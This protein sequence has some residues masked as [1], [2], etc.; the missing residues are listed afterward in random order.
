M[1][2]SKPAVLIWKGVE[3]MAQTS[4]KLLK[5]LGLSTGQQTTPTRKKN[6]KKSKK[7]SKSSYRKPSGE[8]K[9]EWSP[10]V[11]KL[12]AIDLSRT[13]P[14]EVD[15]YRNLLKTI[16]G[17]VTRTRKKLGGN[18][19]Y[20]REA[21]DRELNEMYK[22]KKPS[23]AKLNASLVT[24]ELAKYQ[25][26]FA[27]KTSSAAG[28]TQEQIEQ[29]KRIFGVTENGEARRVLTFEE[30]KAFWSLY[31]SFYE[32]HPNAF[33]RFDSDRV[34]QVL[35]QYMLFDELSTDEIKNLDIV[36]LTKKVFNQLKRE[37]EFDYDLP[38][39]NRLNPNEAFLPK[40]VSSRSL[41]AYRKS[42]EARRKK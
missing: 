39:F 13:K 1:T 32:L 29:S 4:K 2:K 33:G 30:S 12:M 27:S 21:L 19:S 37:T 6:S 28:A 9:Q 42:L 23:T 36:D 18:F 34:Q 40:A 16:R 8:V 15:N 14:N 7:S 11:K 3:K 31:E 24:K 35:S 5:K 26:F 22:G 20:A 10:S 38:K 17:Q 41:S 25:S